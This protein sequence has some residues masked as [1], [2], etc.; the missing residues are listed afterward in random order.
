[1]VVLVRLLGCVAARMLTLYVCLLGV[2]AGIP[3]FVLKGYYQVRVGLDV[4]FVV[5]DM[6]VHHK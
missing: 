5:S 2:C 1:M 6:G 4:C 3:V